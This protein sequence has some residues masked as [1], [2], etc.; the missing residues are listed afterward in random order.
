MQTAPTSPVRTTR[1]VVGAKTEAGRERIRQGQLRRW[2]QIA[3]D[4][5]NLQRVIFVHLSIRKRSGVFAFA[6][7]PCGVYKLRS[8]GVRPGVL[9]IIVV[10]NGVAHFLAL[11]TARADLDRLREK[12]V[13]TSRPPAERGHRPRG[14]TMP[15]PHLRSGATKP[16]THT[17]AFASGRRTDNTTPRQ[18]TPPLRQRPVASTAPRK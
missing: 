13:G 2:Q 18:Q 15:C 8:E 17:S 16:E 12:N 6:V 11:D 10:I 7:P 4:E 14:L 9:D 3:S 1:K 5:Q